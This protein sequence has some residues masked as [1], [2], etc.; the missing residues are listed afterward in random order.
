M[1]ADVQRVG[2]VVMTEGRSPLGGDRYVSPNLRDQG[3]IAIF[4]I[5]LDCS[6]YISEV[7]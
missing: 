1:I 6:N 2:E 3:R 4:G 5:A 7:R